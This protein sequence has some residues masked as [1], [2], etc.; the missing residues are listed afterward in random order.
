YAECRFVEPG[1]PRRSQ[2][3]TAVDTD[4]GPLN[5]YQV[6][7]LVKFWLATPAAR[8]DDPEPLAGAQQAWR[9]PRPVIYGIQQAINGVPLAAIYALLPPAPS[10]GVCLVGR[11]QF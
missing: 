10:P 6:S 3:L 2:D 5:P 4:R 8:A 11:V 9:G 1:R 7:I